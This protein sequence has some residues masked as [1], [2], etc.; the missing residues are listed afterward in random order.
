MAS[1]A[2]SLPVANVPKQ[3]PIITVR[4]DVVYNARRC[5][6]PL[7]LA[8]YTGRVVAQVQ[9]PCP[10][11]SATISALIWI[12]FATRL[13]CSLLPDPLTPAPVALLAH[14]TQDNSSSWHTCIVAICACVATMK[15]YGD[16]MFYLVITLERPRYRRY[17]LPCHAARL[18]ALPG[19][20]A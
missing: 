9:Q 4:N 10:L 15:S 5:E 17:P 1:R 12:L 14:W 20:H 8:R 16:R 7:V 3:Y 6:F 2:Q 13:L 19:S 18:C 11:P